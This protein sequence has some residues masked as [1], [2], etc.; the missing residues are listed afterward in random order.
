[1]NDDGI[2]QMKPGRRLSGRRGARGQDGY[3]L[4]LCILVLALLLLGATYMGA[5]METALGM[6]RAEQQAV[7]QEAAMADARAKV[8]FVLAALPR[9]TQGLGIGAT[10][11]VPDGRL[12]RVDEQVAVRLQDIRGLV[13]LNGLGASGAS[14]QILE[15]LLGT[16]GL[17]SDA[18]ARL[19]D[20]LLDYRD[21]DNLR[22][23]NGAEEEEYRAADKKHSP[24]N[25]DLKTPRELAR[26][27]GWAEENALWGD[28]P[29]SDH[30]SVHARAAFNPNTADWRVLVALSGATPEI[31]KDLL[32]SRRRGE[33]Q[34]I[35]P[36]VASGIAA[37][38]PFAGGPVIVKIPADE[39]LVTFLPKDGRQG[40]RLDVVHTPGTETG[41]WRVQYSERVQVGNALERWEDI[42][43]LPDLAQIQALPKPDQVQ[44][45]F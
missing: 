28:D 31:A 12:Y 6:A 7:R 15:R 27:H 42:P 17:D 20:A 36:L 29:I 44:F 18:T 4:I 9:T 25:A 32:Q 43:M 14:R 10:V 41:P 40:I 5:Q 22:R 11:V 37:A 21:E 19:V 30:V 13:N 38:D 34:D 1:M 8:F 24:R 35:T 39:L 23:I 2:V 45:P 26:I 16:Y 3:I 33:I